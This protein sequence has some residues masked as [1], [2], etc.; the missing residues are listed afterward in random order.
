M[1]IASY[2]GHSAERREES[3][4]AVNLQIQ[5]L[6]A[7]LSRLTDLFL[8]GAFE[9]DLF[10][11]KKLSMLMERQRLEEE[12]A[13]IE[14]GEPISRRKMDAI[15]ELL[16]HVPLSHEM[17]NAHERRRF[18][19]EVTSNFEV[20]GKDVAITLR[21]PFSELANSLA[22]SS[23][24]PDRHR[25]RTLMKTICDLFLKHCATNPP[26]AEPIGAAFP[27]QSQRYA[28]SAPACRQGRPVQACSSPVRRRS[29]E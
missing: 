26:K 14:V 11:D 28:A 17:R 5:R 20:R 18:I 12:R 23:S 13:A 4:R 1:L 25:P 22:V 29:R 6:E 8:D 2:H 9:K 27:H 16:E 24:A 15:L 7:R 10:D 19:E 21:S 3:I